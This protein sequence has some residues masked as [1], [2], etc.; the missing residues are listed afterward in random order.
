MTEWDV[1]FGT[2]RCANCGEI[3]LSLVQT[4]ESGRVVY[5]EI[6]LG[7]PW[8][9][10]RFIIT[11]FF[12]LRSLPKSEWKSKRF[13]GEEVQALYDAFGAGKSPYSEG[14]DLV[15]WLITK[16]SF[17]LRAWKGEKIKVW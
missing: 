6:P 13:T 16:A 9:D 7:C 3:M 2:Y 15:G 4:D 14:L 12:L 8:C 1:Q 11:E 5:Q 10:D 17:M